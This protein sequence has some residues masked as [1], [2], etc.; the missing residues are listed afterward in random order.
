MTQPIAIAVVGHTNAGKTSLLR[1][2]T[3]QGSFGEVSDRPGTTRHVE[4]IDLRIDGRAAVPRLEEALAFGH[5]FGQPRRLGRQTGHPAHQQG[6]D[7]DDDSERDIQGYRIHVAKS[8]VLTR[9]CAVGRPNSLNRAISSRRTIG[10]ARWLD[11]V[12]G[13]DVELAPHPD[14]AGIE[15]LRAGTERPA[16]LGNVPGGAIEVQRDRGDRAGLGRDVAT[17]AHPERAGG[18]GL[19]ERRGRRRAPVDLEHALR[20]VGQADAPD[21]GAALVGVGASEDQPVLDGVERGESILRTSINTGV[22]TPVVLQMIAVG[23]ESGALD[24]MMKEIADMY[25]SEVEYELKTLA[26][27]IEPI[28]IVT[29]GIMVLILALGI[30]LPLWDLGKVALRK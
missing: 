28:L 8:D 25:Q 24:D 9:G 7:E 26:Q 2:L 27:Q 12:A 5:R 16:I 18:R 1:T 17:S 11:A 6:D 10:L 22:F 30:F 29:L 3:R 15:P 13:E 21:P 4:R 20:L 14:P 19:V 23:E